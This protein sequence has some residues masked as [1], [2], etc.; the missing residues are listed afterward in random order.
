[1]RTT[2]FELICALGKAA[3]LPGPIYE[4]AADRTPGQE[5]SRGHVRNC[6]PGREF[7]TSDMA[8]AAGIDKVLDLHNLALPDATVGTAILLDAIEHVERPWRALE[9]IARVLKPGG[10]VVMTSVMYFPIHEY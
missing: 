1:M 3:E 6:F 2:V 8:A 9:E 4:F 7:I 5:K 10:V